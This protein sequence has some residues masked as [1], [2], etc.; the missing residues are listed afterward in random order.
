MEPD[1]PAQALWDG[2][3]PSLQEAKQ[4]FLPEGDVLSIS[5]APR[6]LKALLDEGGAM[7]NLLYDVH[8]KN[9]GLAALLAPTAAACV[10]LRAGRLNP[11]LY[12][13]KQRRRKS[14]SEIRL[15]QLAAS[16]SAEAFV[17][18]MKAS[19]RSDDVRRATTEGM[20]S[21]RFEY[22]C[23][24]RDA[25]RLAYPCVV[26]GGVHATTLHY[27][28]NN[29]PLNIGDLLL[30]DA[31]ASYGGYC[32]DITRT[33]PLS[34]TFSPAQKD[35]YS[36]VLEINRACIDACTTG[37]SLGALHSLSFK[38]SAEALVQLGVTG[39]GRKNDQATISRFYPHAIGH[40][41]GLDVHD[42]PNSSLGEC[43][44]PGVTLTI[45]PG[46]YF[47]ADDETVPAHFR[48]IGVRIED[49]VLVSEAGPLVF[50][51]GAPKDAAGIEEL[52]SL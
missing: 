43:L 27:M 36:A 52:L 21:A 41:L 38:L 3:R 25:E 51:G 19:V 16:A 30:M 31:G 28:Q 42:C 48:G 15:M 13:Q 12:V 9:S 11:G 49:D 17:A 47:R 2:N 7:K 20:L 14:P 5:E 32:A 1:D 44:E 23:K 37:V 22:E 4:H 39:S 50:T 8:A 45:E 26:A 6:R 18:T 35:V 34:G 46:L 10:E 24:V 40:Y 29:A 33:W